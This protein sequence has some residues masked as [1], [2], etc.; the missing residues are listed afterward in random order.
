VERQQEG[1]ASTIYESGKRQHGQLNQTLFQPCSQVEI[2]IAL[3]RRKQD[4][5]RVVE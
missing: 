5:S 1:G 2:E 3:E 4:S